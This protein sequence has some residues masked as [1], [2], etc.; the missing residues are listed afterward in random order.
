MMGKRAGIV[1][2]PATCTVGLKVRHR[3]TFLSKIAHLWARFSVLCARAEL[4]NIR[5]CPIRL[6]VGYMQTW[7]VLTDLAA[8]SLKVD[9]D[10]RF[11]IFCCAHLR[12]T[13]HVCCKSQLQN[14]YYALRSYTSTIRWHELRFHTLKCRLEKV[15]QKTRLFCKTCHFW[16]KNSNLYS[17]GKVTVYL[18]SYAPTHVLHAN[19]LG[20]S[21]SHAVAELRAFK[22]KV[23]F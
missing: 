17:N 14:Y 7:L 4:F 22:C 5:M 11:C 19:M 20:G 10:R 16:A 6:W 9:T 18:L 13:L 2:S 21:I 23:Y 12:A 8:V 15:A 3:Q 1:V